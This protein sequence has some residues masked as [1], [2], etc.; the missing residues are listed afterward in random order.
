L[1]TRLL[2][3][4]V[5]FT[6]WPLSSGAAPVDLSERFKG[7]RDSVVTVICET[8]EADQSAGAGQTT[9]TGQL[10]SGV[11]ISGSG[12]VI[13]AAHLVK[14][15]GRVTVRFANGETSM[16]T[17]ATVA[18]LADVALLQLDHV[19]DQS[20]MAKLADSGT[21]EVGDPVFVVGAPYGLNQTLTAGHLSARHP[22]NPIAGGITTGELFQ[23]DAAVNLGNSGGPMFNM[24]GEV[25]GIVSHI[26]SRS[27]GSEGLG[28]AVT[29]NTARRLLLEQP[30]PWLGFEGV[31][32]SDKVAAAFNLS[33]P[34][35]ILVQSV[36]K[37]SPAARLGLRAGTVDG[38][39]GSESVSFGGDII[40]ELM[41]VP[42]T[43][44]ATTFAEI[45]N[46]LVGLGDGGVLRA[47]VLRAG[48]VLEL[49]MELDRNAGAPLELSQTRTDQPAVPL[50]IRREETP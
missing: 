37:G 49:A 8:H 21:V 27:G 23:T 50:S 5:L 30:T 43:S 12:Q 7:V 22:P 39:I 2:M 32:V 10:G 20:A 41:G 25:I 40:L 26:L 3:L 11:L 4:I 24:Q 34:M 33:Q 44:N 35:G 15:A 45:R 14:D 16:A 17:V 18:P 38:R 1:R 47:K 28:F 13:T 19:P 29:S 36:A 31:L 9:S 46:Q 42:I 48:E 6:L